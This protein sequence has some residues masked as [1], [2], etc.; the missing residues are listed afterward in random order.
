MNK[1][2]VALLISSCL[3]SACANLGLKEQTQAY[4]G[5]FQGN[6]SALS[7]CVV[8]KL[9]SDS[10]WVITGLQYETWT[11]PDIEAS[12]VYGYSMN[13]VPGIFARNSPAN[14]D[15]VGTYPGTPTGMPIPKTHVYRKNAGTP[16]DIN[17]N[18]LF[19]LTL[20]RTDAET[21]FATLNGKRYESDIVWEKLKACADS[22]SG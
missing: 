8:D 2:I 3:L 5:K 6:R 15:A 12:E 9:Q 22:L 17:P 13:D 16:P 7:R 20:K 4:G 21:V 1:P 11:Y 18:Y 10:R 14:P 19:I